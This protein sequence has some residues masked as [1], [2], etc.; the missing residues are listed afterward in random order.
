MMDGAWTN[1]GCGL[2]QCWTGLSHAGLCLGHAGRDL[3]DN[4]Q[5]LD[6]DGQSLDLSSCTRPVWKHQTGSLPSLKLFTTLAPT[7][8]TR[9][10]HSTV[11]S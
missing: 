4:G 3:D 8:T 5:D 1:V 10:L 9:G 6:L 7:C 2:G 11:A